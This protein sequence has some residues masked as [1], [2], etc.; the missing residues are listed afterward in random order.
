MIRKEDVEHAEELQGELRQKT[1]FFLRKNEDGKKDRTTFRVSLEATKSFH[2]E[3][4]VYVISGE[5]RKPLSVFFIPKDPFSKITLAANM[6]TGLNL[7]VLERYCSFVDGE[8]RHKLIEIGGGNQPRQ[9][10][11]DSHQ[12][13]K[14][15]RVDPPPEPRVHVDEPSQKKTRTDLAQDEPT[16]DVSEA[17]VVVAL[18]GDLLT[19]P[20]TTDLK[21]VKAYPGTLLKIPSNLQ[22]ER[23]DLEGRV[24]RSLSR[25]DTAPCI[26]EFV[27]VANLKI[28][29]SSLDWVF[30]VSAPQQGE[31]VDEITFLVVSLDQ[32][33]KARD[34][35][36]SRVP[37]AW[38]SMAFHDTA[39]LLRSLCYSPLSY[40]ASFVEKNGR[41]FQHV[42]LEG[43]VVLIVSI[44]ACSRYFPGQKNQF[45]VATFESLLEAE[46]FVQTSSLLNG[47][48][49]GVPESLRGTT[50]ADF[51]YTWVIG[52]L[53][54]G[55]CATHLPRALSVFSSVI[56]SLEIDYHC[57][58]V[59]Q[60]MEKWFKR[61]WGES[62]RQGFEEPVPSDLGF[63]ELVFLD[64]MTF[65]RSWVGSLDLDELS[66]DT[67]LP[68]FAGEDTDRNPYIP[69]PPYSS[70]PFWWPWNFLL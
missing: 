48:E 57:P 51:F 19:F 65:N 20:L 3:V 42:D 55:K 13:A 6:P 33:L 35:E 46:K 27:D 50:W 62:G 16:R 14:G 23:R 41:I 43:P 52:S 70:G 5:E 9:V 24:C 60:I 36:S 25:I 47:S 30:I 37:S 32:A 18:P 56:S 12:Q 38:L 39:R 15:K 63:G 44:T 34:A 21:M 29:Y 26:P 31:S 69:L 17:R 49:Y 64:D 7:L 66:E 67:D 11:K 1:F 54:N 28:E 22:W 10:P 2:F 40:L 8:V 58:N 61:R 53:N 45:L 68:P 59:L 4:T